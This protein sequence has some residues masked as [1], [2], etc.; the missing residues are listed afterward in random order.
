M[1]SFLACYL[2]LVLLDL[3]T[4]FH[5]IK[6]NSPIMMKDSKAKHMSCG[7]NCCLKLHVVCKCT[8]NNIKWLI[9]MK[10]KPQKLPITY[11]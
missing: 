5:D 8:L 10:S 4:L 2:S 7:I 9:C 3:H 1:M 11:D 6:Y